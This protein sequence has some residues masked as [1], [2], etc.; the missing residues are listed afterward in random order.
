MLE[1][2][3]NRNVIFIVIII[4]CILVGH[5]LPTKVIQIASI[6]MSTCAI[7]IFI[8]RIKKTGK[9]LAVLGD[10]KLMGH[11]LPLFA[12]ST[13]FLLSLIKIFHEVI[14]SSTNL[15]YILSLL[16]GLSLMG[17]YMVVHFTRYLI[18]EK[19]IIIKNE[20]IEW[21]IITAYEWDSVE[22]NLLT[23]TV[24]DNYYGEDE[25]ISYSFRGR[26]NKVNKI[27]SRF[28]ANKAE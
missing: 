9:I 26:K 4:V 27:L 11:I 13:V 22:K 17:V 18:V 7:L 20:L 12:C 10:E 6:L 23:I 3:K 24:K 16:V 15:A 1:K 28:I 25:T 21:N 2:F 5:Y 19:G 8:R 14:L